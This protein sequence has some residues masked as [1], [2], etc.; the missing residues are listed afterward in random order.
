MDKDTLSILQLI[1]NREFVSVS[2]LDFI[3]ND[4]LLSSGE[5]L[6]WLLDH[7]YIK[8]YD[9]DTGMS[10]E[11]MFC[12]THKGKMYLNNRNDLDRKSFWKEFRAWFT[13]AIALAAFIKSFFL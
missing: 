9:G 13:L 1:A 4:S 11:S 7:G 10:P 8:H 12:V 6:E 5:F 2:D 3:L